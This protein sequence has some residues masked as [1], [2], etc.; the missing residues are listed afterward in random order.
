MS[1]SALNA[2]NNGNLHGFRYNMGNMGVSG[3]PLHELDVTVSGSTDL[4]GVRKSRIEHHKSD[5]N[6]LLESKYTVG[7]KLGQGAF[8]T[9]R[10]VHES[11]APERQFAVKT[12]KKRHGSTA[13]AEQLVREIVIMKKVSHPH[14]VKLFEVYETPQRF[15]LVMEYCPNG[16]LINKIRGV[17][18]VTH[19]QVHTIMTRLLSAVSYLHEFGIVHR[20]IKPENILLAHERNGDL[21][22]VKLSDFGLATY[23]NACVMMDNVCGTP[24]YMAPEVCNNLP[25]SQQCDIWSCGVIMYLLFCHFHREMEPILQQMILNGK[26]EFSDRYFASVSESA[27]QIIDSMLKFDPAYRLTASE[28]TRHYYITGQAAQ[29]GSTVPRQTV[30]DLMKSY[31]SERRLRKAAFAAFAVVCFCKSVNVPIN[32]VALPEASSQGSTAYSEAPTHGRNDSEVTGEQAVSSSLANLSVDNGGSAFH[33]STQTRGKSV[34]D[35]REL[36]SSRTNLIHGVSASSIPN[37]VSVAQSRKVSQ[38]VAGQGQSVY[39][40]TAGAGVGVGKPKTKA[41][42]ENAIPR[43]SGPVSSSKTN[44]TGLNSPSLKPVSSAAASKATKLKL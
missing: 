14:V 11:L 26:I 18:S 17:G 25:Y 38:T 28:A 44:S 35:S 24:F 15:A 22:D 4:S 32:R 1:E 12:I 13:H 16:D 43:K 34:R 33:L 8:G 20:D 41:V 42:T 37:S 3:R 36:A 5:G 7:V 30:F 21:Y 29:N 19:E 31:N 40:A 2:K 10:L 6:D 39:A 27:R 9:V 23:T